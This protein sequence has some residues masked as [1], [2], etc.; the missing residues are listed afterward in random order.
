MS[1]ALLSRCSVR[2]NFLKR[3]FDV[4]FSAVVLSLGS[5]IY[6]A[7]AL[8][9]RIS[10]PGPAF[11]ACTRVGRGGKRIRC[12]KFRSMCI[13][14]EKRLEELLASDPALR[15][16]WEMYY[17]LKRDP[18]I[19]FVGKLLR[20]TSLDELPQFWNVLK[21][22]LSVVGPRPITEEEVTKYLK[23]KAAKILSVRPGITGLWQTSG[24]NLLTFDERIK[25][26]EEYV[27][28][29]SFALDCLLVFKTVPAVLFPK[30]AF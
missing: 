23:E 4:L 28:R 15:Q 11:Y 20:K 17:K 21:G 7:I 25:L 24:R 8:L 30:G 26:E 12:W 18:R 2:H 10:S 6:L 13:D 14:A 9:I 22:D 29:Q 19:F 3:A 27:D 1:I 16:E 5:P